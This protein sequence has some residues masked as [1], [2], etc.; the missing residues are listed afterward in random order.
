MQQGPVPGDEGF[1]RTNPEKA[2]EL[3]QAQIAGVKQEINQLTGSLTPGT[4]D[5]RES[6][7]EAQLESAGDRLGSLE[8]QLDCVISGEASNACMGEPPPPPPQFGPSN[9]VPEGVIAIVQMVLTSAVILALGVPLI[10]L[11]VRRMEHKLRPTEAP[12]EAGPR[13]ERLEQAMDAVAIE[14]ERISEGQRFTNRMIGEMR[15]L[16]AGAAQWQ[17]AAQREA[18]AVPRSDQG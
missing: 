14:V 5:A 1:R 9:E 17:G 18:V 13:M 7:V 2:I 4:S 11:L 16:P 15:G 3:I 10:R 6:A 8:R 12:A